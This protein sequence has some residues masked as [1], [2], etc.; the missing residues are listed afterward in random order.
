VSASPGRRSGPITPGR[1]QA[2]CVGQRPSFERSG[3]KSASSARAARRREQSLLPPPRANLRRKTQGCDRPHR[4]RLRRI[5]IKPTLP[6]HTHVPARSIAM[7]SDRCERDS[8]GLRPLAVN[9]SPTLTRLSAACRWGSVTLKTCTIPPD[10]STLMLP[11]QAAGT[12][13]PCLSSKLFSAAATGQGRRHDHETTVDHALMRGLVAAG[14][15]MRRGA[16]SV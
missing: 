3:S 10:G 5:P 6:G 4:P 7:W 13:I 11:F 16:S 1:Y 9:E 2:G 14:P 15:V 12:Y 8:E